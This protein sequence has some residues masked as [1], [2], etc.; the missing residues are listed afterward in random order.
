MWP[1]TLSTP[2]TVPHDVSSYY[3]RLTAGGAREAAPQSLRWRP[4]ADVL[5]NLSEFPFLG[6]VRDALADLLRHPDV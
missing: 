6:P 5:T 4:A 2:V 3:P 1:A